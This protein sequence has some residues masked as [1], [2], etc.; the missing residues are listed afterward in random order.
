MLR[1]YKSQIWAHGYLFFP[2]FYFFECSI[3]K[4][5]KELPSLSEM[6]MLSVKPCLFPMFL[7]V[8]LSMGLVKIVHDCIA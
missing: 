5:S 8:L 2:Y 4:L 6:W 3:S 7:H 1:I